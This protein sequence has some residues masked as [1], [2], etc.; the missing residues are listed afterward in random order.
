MSSST[1]KIEPDTKISHGG[2]NWLGSYR[3]SP[4]VTG[5]E[6]VQNAFATEILDY[7]N[8]NWIQVEDYPK[9]YLDPN[10]DRYVAPE[11]LSLD[12]S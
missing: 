8:G 3:D 4:F 5:S 7:K 1:G 2:A 6:G 9:R 10:G 11:S 12:E